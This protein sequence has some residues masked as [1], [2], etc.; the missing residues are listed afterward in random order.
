MIVIQKW[1]D[2][3]PPNWIVNLEVFPDS[4]DQTTQQL[5][6]MFC[7]L[8]HYCSFLLPF[9]CFL[10]LH[11]Y[12]PVFL[13]LQQCPTRCQHQ[14]R[15]TQGDLKEQQIVSL[16]CGGSVL[17]KR[18]QNDTHNNPCQHCSLFTTGRTVDG[19]QDGYT[20]LC[21]CCVTNAVL[22]F[23]QVVTIVVA[24]WV[25]VAHVV[26]LITGSSN[27]IGPSTCGCQIVHTYVVCGQEKVGLCKKKKEEQFCFNNIKE[28]CVYIRTCCHS[29]RTSH[30]RGTC[31]SVVDNHR[32]IVETPTFLAGDVVGIAAPTNE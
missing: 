4:Q 8:M 30:A 16:V 2:W 22:Q 32:K 13:S 14:S 1:S 27:A 24:I 20:S 28:K 5:A 3:I 9:L 17:L 19:G 18:T 11:L 10:C 23:P 29:R 15:P 21:G 25:A 31:D 12:H 7:C 26:C 6:L